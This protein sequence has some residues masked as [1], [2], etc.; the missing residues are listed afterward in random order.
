MEQVKVLKKVTRMTYPNR[1]EV[2]IPIKE[3]VKNITDKA[4]GYQVI[5]VCYE[6][7]LVSVQDLQSMIKNETGIE[8][9]F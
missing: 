2:V 7:G 1:M 5:K 8:I 6:K 3:F 4:K 9:K